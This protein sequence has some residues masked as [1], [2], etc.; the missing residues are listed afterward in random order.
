MATI[1]QFGREGYRN[2]QS[3]CSNALIPTLHMS[4]KEWVKLMTSSLKMTDNNLDST[5]MSDVACYCNYLNSLLHEGHRWHNYLVFVTVNEIR[6]F[7]LSPYSQ[8]LTVK[9]GHYWY[10]FFQ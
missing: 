7:A 4:R 5:G 8:S 1:C 6:V 9:A 10:K 3:D 2:L